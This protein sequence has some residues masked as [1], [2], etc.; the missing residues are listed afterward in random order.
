[1]RTLLGLVPPK[2]VRVDT[3]S[4]ARST[5]AMRSGA[6]KSEAVKAEKAQLAVAAAN[7][8]GVAANAP[9]EANKN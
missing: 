5:A 4:K 3:T 7:T 8:T 6:T 1:M 9:I 2:S